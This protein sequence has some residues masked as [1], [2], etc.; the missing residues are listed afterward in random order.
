MKLPRRKYAKK[1]KSSIVKMVKVCFAPCRCF[2][3]GKKH[4]LKLGR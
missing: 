3:A 4:K 2:S 1:G